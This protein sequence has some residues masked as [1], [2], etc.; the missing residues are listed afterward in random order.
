M[1]GKGRWGKEHP[2]PAK[3]RR[4]GQIWFEGLVEG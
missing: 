4:R 1:E 3:G 2:H